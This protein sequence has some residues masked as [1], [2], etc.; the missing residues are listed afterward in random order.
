MSGF[1]E[2]SL[3]FLKALEAH[4][5]RDWFA[6]HKSDYE[7]ELKLPAEDYCEAMRMKLE[8]LCGIDHKAKI[9][10]IYRD[11]RFSKDKTPYNAHVRMS[12]VPVTGPSSKPGWFF[13]LEP[14]HVVL[15]VG[16]FQY[17]KAALDEWRA[18]VAGDDGAGL[19]KMLDKLVRDGFRM[20]EPDLKRVP[21]SYPPDHPRAEFL[22]RKGLNV[23][24]DF[25]DASPALGGSAASTCLNNFRKM[26]PVFDWLMAAD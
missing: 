2:D 6:A 5:D 18:R 16:V 12:F 20:N 24:Y 9:F 21:S 22:R 25:A 15:G 10:R 4:N 3:S 14:D 13:S 1:T 17:D 7:R 19:E 23:W 26:K 11:V 8:A